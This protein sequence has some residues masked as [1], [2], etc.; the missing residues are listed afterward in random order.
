MHIG[1]LRQLTN[2]TDLL[3]DNVLKNTGRVTGVGKV[4]RFPLFAWKVSGNSQ[5]PGSVSCSLG[6][7]RKAKSKITDLSVLTSEQPVLGMVYYNNGTQ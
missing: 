6:R 3:T 7:T 4:I 1:P 5:V 2:V